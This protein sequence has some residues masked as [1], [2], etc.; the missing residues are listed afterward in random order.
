[1]G[2]MQYDLNT[3]PNYNLID[4]NGLTPAGQAFGQMYTQLL[5]R[6]KGE[7]IVTLPEVTS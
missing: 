1:M 2:A 4:G 6:K 7:S 3:N 5:H